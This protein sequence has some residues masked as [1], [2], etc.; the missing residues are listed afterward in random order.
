[1]NIAFCICQLRAQRLQTL[2]YEE[3]LELWNLENEQFAELVIQPTLTY[4]QR[5][6]ER[7]PVQTEGGL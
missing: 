6:F 4:Y 3:R 1:M 2:S 7:A 5:Y